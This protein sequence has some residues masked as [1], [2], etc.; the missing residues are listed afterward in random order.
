VGPPP[1]HPFPHPD[2]CQVVLA[3][4]VGERDGGPEAI[5]L[6]DGEVV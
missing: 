5:P 1:D 2:F 3:A 4:R 6:E